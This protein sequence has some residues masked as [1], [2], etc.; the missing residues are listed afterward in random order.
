MS[1]LLT[2]WAAF[3]KG[4][5]LH[6]LVFCASC[7]VPCAWVGSTGKTFFAVLDGLV[8]K[9][10][11]GTAHRVKSVHITEDGVEQARERQKKYSER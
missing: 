8:K 5:D 10:Y 9:G 11:L 7:N 3:K 6:S 1:L 2:P 4:V